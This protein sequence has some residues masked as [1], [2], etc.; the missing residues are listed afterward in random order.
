[1]RAI[2]YLTSIAII[3]GLI[4][5][6]THSARADDS[7]PGSIKM[8]DG[9]KHQ[10]LQGTDS[11]VG[12]IWK[13]GGITIQYDIGLMA[14]NYAKQQRKHKADHLLWDKLQTWNGE[15]VE[16][17]MMKDRLLYVSFPKRHANFYCKVKEEQDIIDALLM[18]LT[19]IPVKEAEK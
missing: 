17:A 14:G 15:P 7:L 16:M 5:V 3:V 9:Y 2:Y 4:G 11:Q 18:V 12:K 8:L 10:K 19:Y 13:D 6:G 1:M